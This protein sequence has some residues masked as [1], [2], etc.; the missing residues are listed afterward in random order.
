M[1][2]DADYVFQLEVKITAPSNSRAELIG[3]YRAAVGASALGKLS[4][5]AGLRSMLERQAHRTISSGETNR[6]HIPYH[7]PTMQRAAV[8]GKDALG[9]SCSR[10]CKGRAR[11]LWVEL[12]SSAPRARHFVWQQQYAQRCA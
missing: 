4:W 2:S 3:N 12:F 7:L 10:K 5:S 11:K 6:N 8:L 1:S 9:E